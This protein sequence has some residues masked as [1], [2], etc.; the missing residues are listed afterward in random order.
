MEQRRANYLFTESMEYPEN[1]ATLY[2]TAGEMARWEQALPRGALHLRVPCSRLVSLYNE[3]L[4]RTDVPFHPN[5]N[6]SALLQALGATEPVLSTRIDDDGIDGEQVGVFTTASKKVMVVITP[7]ADTL[8]KLRKLDEN[9]SCTLIL[10]N[11]QVRT[12]W[13][14]PSFEHWPSSRVAHTTRTLWQHVPTCPL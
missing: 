14:G 5:P 12:H 8:K 3:G 10:M 1:A 6:G 13:Y 4:H 9:K 2:G 7:T 11:P